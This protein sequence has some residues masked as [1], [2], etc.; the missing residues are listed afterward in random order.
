MPSGESQLT[1][2]YGNWLS[3]DI[4]REKV[5]DY[6]KALSALLE[7]DAFLTAE[8]YHRAVA[9]HLS[10]R[11]TAWKEN[12]HALV[13][14]ADELDDHRNKD[15]RED[16]TQDLNTLTGDYQTA[17]TEYETARSRLENYIRNLS[18]ELQTETADL[19]VQLEQISEKLKQDNL[20][21]EAAEID[22]V[23]TRLEKRENVQKDFVSYIE[24]NAR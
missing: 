10:G 23:I 4:L 19:Q 12:I 3:S 13:A 18:L 8:R 21:S 22:A 24:N 11:N 14:M 17:Y 16:R 9:V 15:F 7:A 6:G 5:P 1:I 2:R 20:L